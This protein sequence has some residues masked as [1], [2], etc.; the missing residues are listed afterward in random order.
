M[1]GFR[2]E[3]NT[4]SNVVEVNDDHELQV[5]LTRDN[6]KAGYAIIFSESDPGTVTG[7]PLNRSPETS[8]D[9]R[10]RTGMDTLFWSETFNYS[11]QNTASWCYRTSTLTTTWGAGY[12]TLNG[13]GVTT[14]GST[15]NNSYRSFPLFGT[16]PLYFETNAAF[17]TNPPSNFLVDFGLFING[18]SAPYAPTDGAYFRMTS[19]GLIGV[20]NYNGVETQSGVLMLASDV[21]SNKN[22]KFVIT[23]DERGVEFWADEVLL[24]TLTTPTG[25]GQPCQSAALPAAMRLY[26]AG[27]AGA[28]CQF[29]VSNVTV[30]SADVNSQKMWPLQLAGMGL[31]A[32]QGPPGGTM[33]S[34]AAVTNNAN[35][36]TGSLANTTAL[37]SGFGGEAAFN[38]AAATAL[39]GIVVSYQNPVGSVTYSSRTMYI[40]GV[41]ISAVNMGAAVASTPTTIAWTLAFGHTAV[42]L[43]TA[44]S[45]TTKAPR[46]IALGISNWAV[47]AD[48]GSR[49]EYGDV[50]MTF[51]SPVIVYQGEFVAV[52]A[53]FIN[54]TATA[55]QRIYAHVT[56]DA[57]FE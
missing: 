21:T 16:S 7:A 5:A 1:A 12:V 9:Y 15:V 39:D 18:T 10:I 54:G 3:G 26:H 33:G 28:V 37:V 14:A 32:Y 55:S 25:Y 47:G 50:V 42:S 24:G 30:S 57:F 41:K 23:L 8:R 53:K 45:A 31:C 20:V 38:A 49:P 11:A 46:R 19:A 44:N 17:T 29:K 22:I 2:I 27:T 51:N 34:T 35:P 43:A 13:S 40:T 56:Y 52:T 36:S 6:A 48:V 4:S